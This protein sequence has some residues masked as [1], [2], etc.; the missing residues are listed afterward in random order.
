[1]QPARKASATRAQPAKKT[2]MEQNQHGVDCGE[3]IGGT[4]CRDHTGGKWSTWIF[5]AETQKERR[6]RILREFGESG[7]L[8]MFDIDNEEVEKMK[9]DDIALM[10]FGFKYLKYV[11]ML[12]ETLKVKEE[13]KKK[14]EVP[15]D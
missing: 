2:F 6:K 5:R 4:V 7:F 12:E 10:K 3:A 8:N 13:Y 9:S 14:A 1:M 15:A 11:L